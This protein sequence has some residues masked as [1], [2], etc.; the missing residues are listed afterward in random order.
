MVQALYTAEAVARGEGRD[1]EVTSSDGIIDETL[2][3]PKELGGPGGEHTNP[4]QLFAAGYAA[5]FHSALKAAARQLK[6]DPGDSQVTARVGIGKNDLGKF[7]LTVE[8]EARLSGMEQGKADE[9]VAEAHQ[10]CPYSSATRGNIEVKVTAT[11]T[12]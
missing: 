6:T 2:T 7:E 10:L 1:G 8:L 5:C 11:T 12:D 9:L 3:T 4:E